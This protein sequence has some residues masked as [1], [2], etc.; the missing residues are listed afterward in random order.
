MRLHSIADVVG[1]FPK[2]TVRPKDVEEAL[3]RTG[4]YRQIGKAK[5]L[6]ED[7]LR[8]FMRD[9][10]VAK[11][12]ELP[13]QDH[14]AGQLV[15]IGSPTISESF[16]WVGWSPIGQELM[17]LDQVRIGASEA[18]MVLATASMSFGDHKAFRKKWSKNHEFGHWYCRS[19]PLMRA[20]DELMNAEM[21]GEQDG[22]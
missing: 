12:N 15:V 19:A 13:P 14:E 2:D 4:R 18:V 11:I 1:L 7:D 9:I 8:A 5:V 16:V 21:D 20:V 6:T 10:L 3:E 17:L 22:E